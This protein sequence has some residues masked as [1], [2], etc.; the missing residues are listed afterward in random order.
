MKYFL[1]S[2][3]VVVDQLS[4]GGQIVLIAWSLHPLIFD[5]IWH[6]EGGG[7]RPVVT[8]FAT[9]QNKQLLISFSPLPDPLAGKEDTFYCKWDHLEACM[10][11][12]FAL[13][14]R[15]LNLIGS[16]G[17]MMILDAP[18]LASLRV[19]TGSSVATGEVI[20]A[21]PGVVSA[22]ATACPQVPPCPGHHQFPWGCPVTPQKE[23]FLIG[24]QRD[25]R[26]HQKIILKTLPGEVVCLL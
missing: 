23:S 21:S 12:P 10:F 7:G 20:V 4:C 25:V 5:K 24:P 6:W 8:V 16:T 18:T 22:N 26:L 13:I 14:H 17:I 1:G 19:I 2:V 3:N 11:P 9:S 15:L